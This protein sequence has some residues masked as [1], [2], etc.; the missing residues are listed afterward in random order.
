MPLSCPSKIQ[1]N[2]HCPQGVRTI[3]CSSRQIGIDIHF[4]KKRANAGHKVAPGAKCKCHQVISSSAGL[5]C[6]QASGPQAPCGTS[7]HVPVILLLPIWPVRRG[8]IHTMSAGISVAPRP[9]C[10]CAGPYTLPLLFILHL[11]HRGVQD[12]SGLPAYHILDLIATRKVSI[13]KQTCR[14]TKCPSHCFF[15]C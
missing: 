3:G 11:P 2:H 9:L 8:V 10:S 6:S 5:G 12:V 1:N 15:A 13:K 4:A 14:L 7:A